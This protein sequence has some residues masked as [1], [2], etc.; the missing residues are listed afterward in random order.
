MFCGGGV[1]ISSRCCYR[2]VM[3]HCF[4]YSRLSSFQFWSHTNV[5]SSLVFTESRYRAEYVELWADVTGM[6]AEVLN[7][8]MHACSARNPGGV[9][10]RP[11]CVVRVEAVLGGRETISAVACVLWRGLANYMSHYLPFHYHCLPFRDT[12]PRFFIHLVSSSPPLPSS[13]RVCTFT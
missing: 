9:E 2:V 1:I 6:L 11:A 8:V 12:F 10:P 5:N 4:N 7:Q 13:R 3:L